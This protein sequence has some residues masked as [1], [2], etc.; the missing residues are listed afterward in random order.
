MMKNNLD[1]A[2]EDHRDEWMKETKKKKKKSIDWF[3]IYLSNASERW[4]KGKRK[5]SYTI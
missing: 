4:K 5:S 3:E 1:L 2:R